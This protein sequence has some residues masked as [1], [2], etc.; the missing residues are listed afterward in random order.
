MSEERYH[1]PDDGATGHSAQCNAT[2]LDAAR[3]VGQ[4]SPQLADRLL[5]IAINFRPFTS[6]DGEFAA[7]LRTGYQRMARTHRLPKP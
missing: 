4:L 5:R 7:A 3:Q 6:T 2:L 1:V